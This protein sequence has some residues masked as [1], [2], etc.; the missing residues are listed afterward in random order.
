VQSAHNVRVGPLSILCAQ[1]GISGS[2][3]LGTGVVLAGQ[4]GVVGHLTLGDGAKVAAQSGVAHDVEPG[5]MVSGYPAVE[6]GLWL[7]QAAALKQLPEL[8]KEIR[9]LRADRGA[10]VEE[11]RPGR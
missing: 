3:N 7:R 1:V 8:L 6:R 2:A 11:G 9:T 5:G 4:V 10:G